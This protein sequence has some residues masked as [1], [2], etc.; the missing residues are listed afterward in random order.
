MSWILFVKSNIKLHLR[1]LFMS[2]TFFIIYQALV[3]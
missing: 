3:E 2:A 1:P